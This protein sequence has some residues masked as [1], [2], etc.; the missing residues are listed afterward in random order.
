[1][2]DLEP[3]VGVLTDARDQVRLAG[4][5]RDGGGEHRR[6][7]GR[8]TGQPH[9]HRIGTRRYREVLGHDPVPDALEN[10]GRTA[11][12]RAEVDVDVRGVRR[13]VGE[14]DIADLIGGRGGDDSYGTDCDRYRQHGEEPAENT[15]DETS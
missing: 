15:R 10:L 12:D 13:Q 3:E 7:G 2:D 9:R 8:G 1:V 11:A 4:V 6:V 5:H 14:A